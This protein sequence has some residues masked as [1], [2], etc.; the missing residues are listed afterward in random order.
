MGPMLPMVGR[1][2]ELA[3][4]ERAA[5]E[6]PQLVVMRGRRRVGKSFLV[7]R[8]FQDRERFLYFQADDGA[9][10]LHLDLIASECQRFSGAPVAFEDWDAALG[11]LGRLAEDAPLVVALDEFQWMWF[12]QPA[13]PSK[14]MRHFDDWSRRD[15]PICLVLA[16]SAL[17]AMEELVEG[18]EP[19]FGRAAARPLIQP[20]DYRL[21]AEFG[22]AGA[23]AEDAL[24]RYA[25]LGGTAQYQVWAGTGDLESVLKERV[26]AR[27]ESLFEEPLQLLR[28][29]RDL[30]DPGSYYGVMRAI[31]T[32]SNQFSEILQAAGKP[33]GNA[34][35][36]RLKRLE[37]LGYVELREPIAS[38]GTKSYTLE[39]PYFRFWFRYVYPNRSRLQ[40]GRI[41]EVYD[42]IVAD[43]DNFMGPVFEAVCRDWAGRY[44]SSG[45]LATSGQI[46][47]L[48][49]R[50]HDI[51]I[52]V[53]GMTRQRYDA[54]GSC[55]WSNHADG[56]D[57]DRLIKLRD[58]VRGAG[59]APLF[60]FARG[61]HRSL[62]ARADAGE[63]TLVR[64]EDLY[65]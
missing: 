4:L 55:K 22:P 28:G 47:A 49:T 20:F 43:L 25:I 21:A 8:A 16:G 40:R 53:V 44:A 61:F 46:G 27:D 37:D 41:E 31:A 17:S 12:A 23:T 7:N 36:S 62:L 33:T 42:D 29:E 11:Y 2:T 45:P 26:L 54:L 63:V 38:N 9:E 60:L 34:L 18:D 1:T 30:R 48:W 5:D 24:R 59:A 58:G 51:E 65:A 14:I 19:M 6:P 32:G 35:N 64:A 10:R 3:R 15:V 50:T 52:D 57:L 56:H 39:D 13:L